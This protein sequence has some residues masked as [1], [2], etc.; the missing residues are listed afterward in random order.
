MVCPSSSSIKTLLPTVNI[1]SKYSL[2]S[3][4]NSSYNYGANRTLKKYRKDKTYKIRQVQKLIRP[5]QR[6]T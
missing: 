3:P 6:P 5:P 1:V 2:D 4:P